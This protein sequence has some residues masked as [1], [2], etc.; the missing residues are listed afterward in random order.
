MLTVVAT[1]RTSPPSSMGANGKSRLACFALL[2]TISVTGRLILA[3]AKLRPFKIGVR[4]ILRLCLRGAGGTW[5]MPMILHWVVK[6]GGPEDEE[7]WIGW[8]AKEIGL[9]ALSGIP[10]VRDIANAVSTG[11]DYKPTP[12]VSIYDAA[13]KSTADIENLSQGEDVS[14]QWLRHSLETAG[15]AFGL[16]TG[17]AAQ[18]L[19]YLPVGPFLA[20]SPM[21]KSQSKV[22]VELPL[23]SNFV[24]I[25]LC[26]NAILHRIPFGAY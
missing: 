7:S 13:R 8:T 23:S 3:G 11:R 12:A 21:G 17:Q 6:G 10:V 24:C 18:S 5:V 2:G 4:R 9:G 26:K 15:Y 19:H 25:S 22:R 20:N 16:P 14:P 1:R